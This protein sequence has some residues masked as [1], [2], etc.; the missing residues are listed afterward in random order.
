DIT[1][2]IFVLDLP[3][4][5]QIQELG[6]MFASEEVSLTEAVKELGRSF[7]YIP[8]QANIKIDSVGITELD[9]VDLK[10]KELDLAY[11]KDH[12][13]LFSIGVFESE[14]ELNGDDMLP[15]DEL[16]TIRGQEAHYSDMDGFRMIVWQEEGI[17]YSA[18][19]EN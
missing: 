3:D 17:N 9:G 11:T 6:E 5:A 15:G 18:F 16:V 1:D 7:Y 4:D 8:E 12:M 19:F 13:P 2:D 14:V 10:R